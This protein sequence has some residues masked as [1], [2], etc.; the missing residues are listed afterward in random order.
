MCPKTD[1]EIEIM[2]CIPHASAISSIMYGMISTRLDIAYALSVTNDS[3]SISGLVFM[4]NGAAVS[5]QGFEQDTVADSTAE[6]EYI[7][8]SIATKEA[9]WM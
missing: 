1:E 4:L 3:K 6:A 7:V 5:W 8:V 9:V 2:T